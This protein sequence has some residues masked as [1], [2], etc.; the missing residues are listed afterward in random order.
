[1]ETAPR[2]SDLAVSCLPHR[3]QRRDE[4]DT[5]AKPTPACVCHKAQADDMRSATM[6]HT[7]LRLLQG[8]NQ[9]GTLE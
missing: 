7:L 6:G 1:V 9:E 5:A 4:A 8:G 3:G 2:H